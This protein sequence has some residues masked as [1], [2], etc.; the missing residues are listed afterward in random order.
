M[1]VGEERLN[2][3]INGCIEND[4]KSQENIYMMFYGKMMGVCMRYTKDPDQAKDILQEGFIKVFRNIGKFNFEGSFEGWI[5]RIMVNT[6]IDFFRKA[7]ALSQYGQ[8][9]LAIE[10]YEDDFKED[11]EEDDDVPPEMEL[12]ISDVVE[13]V[14]YLSPA[15]RTV[16]NLYVFEDY[17]HKDIADALDISV[18]T[19]K[20]NLAKAKANLKRIL[21]KELKRRHDE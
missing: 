4:R 16:F 6:A 13:A 15:Y 12:E 1:S 20:S 5:R 19:S 11:P 10:D 8:D 2:A 14:Q 18:G 17:S 7:K 9:K 21:E 3:L